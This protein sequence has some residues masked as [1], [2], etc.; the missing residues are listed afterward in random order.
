[1]DEDD[2]RFYPSLAF[3]VVAAPQFVLCS[4]TTGI[5]SSTIPNAP[6][7]RVTPDVPSHRL[8]TVLLTEPI[9]FF[10]SEGV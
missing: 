3:F 4:K 2:G 10:F 6:C 1:M 9:F 7:F 5:V 8:H